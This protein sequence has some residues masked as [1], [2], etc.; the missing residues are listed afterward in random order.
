MI[1]VIFID[2]KEYSYI[3]KSLNNVNNIKKKLQGTWI[4]SMAA[5]TC[6]PSIWEAKAGGLWVQGQPGLQSKTLS[7]KQ[8]NKCTKKF[9]EG[10]MDTKLNSLEY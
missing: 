1:S 5:H 6:I 4:T 7:N 10:Q 9:G 8:T 3:N 2:G